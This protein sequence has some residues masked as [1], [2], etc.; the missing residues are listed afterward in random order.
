MPM[1][2][3]EGCRHLRV[4]LLE[5]EGKWDAGDEFVTCVYT[6][7]CIAC[8]VRLNRGDSNDYIALGLTT[9]MGSIVERRRV[10]DVRAEARGRRCV[11][12]H[13]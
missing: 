2:K 13:P 12:R 5:R 11:G 3:L 10:A 4:K 1:P 7:R 6:V 9:K 8:G